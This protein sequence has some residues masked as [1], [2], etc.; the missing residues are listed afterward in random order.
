MIPINCWI[1]QQR[2]FSMAKTKWGEIMSAKSFV[3]GVVIGGIAA[4]VATL[5]ST[6]M[7][8]KEARKTIRDNSQAILTDI[9]EL[10]ISIIDIKDSITTATVEGKAIISSFIEDLK[11]TLNDWKLEIKPHQQQLQLE[12][13]ELE[14]TVNEL[15]TSLK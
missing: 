13:K 7:S 3:T 1:I 14:N 4:G 12:L 11:L 8:G 15:E 9:K 6:P 10:Q 2:C 5:L